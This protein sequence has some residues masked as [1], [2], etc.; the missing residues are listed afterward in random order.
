MDR[1]KPASA[2]A[3]YAGICA[4]AAA[5][6]ALTSTAFTMPAI[7]EVHIHCDDA[8]TAGAEVPRRLGFLLLRA[9]DDK[10]DAPAEIGRSME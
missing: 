3:W 10:V 5:A 2:V 8:N 4:A 6:R 1:I 7:K 9:V